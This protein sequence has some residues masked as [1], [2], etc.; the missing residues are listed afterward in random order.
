M[1]DERRAG[2]QEEGKKE[3]KKQ[4]Q[5]D[6]QQRDPGKMR[7][8]DERASKNREE[9]K[10]NKCQRERVYL[11]VTQRTGRKDVIRKTNH[12]IHKT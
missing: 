6:E 4:G 8:T 10:K 5:E 11:N 3:D 7:T 12:L 2:E 1:R 9:G